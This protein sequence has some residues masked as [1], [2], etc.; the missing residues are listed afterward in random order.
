[1]VSTRIEVTVVIPAYREAINLSVLVP[2]LAT[3][4]RRAGLNGEIIVV[5]DFS[6]DG[7][8]VLCASLSQTFPVRLL[9]RHE[10][11]GL[12]SGEILVVMDAEMSHPPEMVPKLVSACRSPVVDFVIGSRYAEGS[13]VV[14]TYSW[15][16]WLRSRGASLLARGLTAARDPLSGFFATKQSTLQRTDELK[17]LGDKIGLEII[18]RCDVRQIV[19]VPISFT[20]CVFGQR[21]R[22]FVQQWQYARQLARLYGAKYA[23]PTQWICFGLIGISGTIVD[24][25]VF[26]LLLFVAP[27]TISRVA[28]IACA[29]LWNF[30]ANSQITFRSAPAVPVLH[31]LVKYFGATLLG[32][33]INCS[34][35]IVLCATYRL[36]TTTPT[37][38][39][40][41]GAAAGAA[42]NF[43]LCRRWVF[44][45][46]AT[47]DMAADNAQTS[48]AS[49]N[50][51]RVA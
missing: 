18:V 24:L 44:R 32:A 12:A 39:A 41:I 16:R 10:R 20:N 27:L 8:D 31:R 28:A 5:D 51:R 26:F 46:H 40:A 36:F 47:P 1:M 21:S 19:E 45:E 38:A 35:T 3:A 17:P 30:A 29:T 33:A 4:L 25:T 50:R 13:S 43:V 9:T 22:T 49:A 23:A 2:R 37:L 15:S 48:V 6:D 7:T 34:I 14:A 11:R 42:A